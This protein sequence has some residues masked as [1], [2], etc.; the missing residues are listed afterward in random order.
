MDCCFKSTRKPHLE[1]LLSK[2][3]KVPPNNKMDGVKLK[4]GGAMDT[5]KQ[6][7][8]L[9]MA[10]AGVLADAVY[11]VAETLWEGHRCLVNVSGPDK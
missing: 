1:K 6:I 9:Q 11:T 5:N 2:I 7:Q 4:K 3:H 10:Y 8:V